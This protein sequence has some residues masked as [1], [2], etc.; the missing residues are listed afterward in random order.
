[1]KR[2]LIGALAVVAF[3]VAVPASAANKADGH[4]A[5]TEMRNYFHN[6]GAPLPSSPLFTTQ[7]EFDRHF[8]PAAFMGKD[9]RPTPVNFR[10]QAVVA[11]VL[12][13]TETETDIDSVV[14]DATGKKELTLRYIVRRGADMGYTV[15]PVRL[16][17]VPKKY[18]GWQVKVKA[19]E[20][21]EVE[22]SSATLTTVTYN[23]EARDIHMQVDFPVKG[24]KLLTDSVRA[25]ILRTLN[26]YADRWTATD[27]TPKGSVTWTTPE[28]TVAGC[29]AIVWQQMKLWNAEIP[30]D[31]N[32]H[33]SALLTLQRTDETTRY[34]TYETDT[35]S[36]M[37]G[38][39]GIGSHTGV[40][41]DKQTGRRLQ[42][43]KDGEGL[44]KLITE[45][46]HKNY[47][48]ITFDVEPVPLPANGVFMR[49]G[50]VV[51][52]YQPYEIGPYAIGMPEVSVWPYQIEQW[53]VDAPM[54]Q[55]E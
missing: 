43:V 48:G 27:S 3:M 15:Q 44:R 36:F 42:I 49:D 32:V 19:D 18:A 46:L 37:G 55:G 24:S 54:L 5:L 29:A 31:I 10:K 38:A 4:V 26:A 47:D 35:Y 40:T 16:F 50:K 17:L 1:M 9:G 52:V 45:E 41:F 21:R 53:I 28:R 39:H 22:E 33:S 11:V 6:N 14:L 25:Y 8:S 51:F 34:V 20:R 7:A 2:K 23:S 13:E 30:K 12:P